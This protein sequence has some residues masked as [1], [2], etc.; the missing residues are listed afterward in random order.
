MLNYIVSRLELILEKTGEDDNLMILS[1]DSK[2]NIQ[3][4]NYIPTSTTIGA[5]L[6][7]VK[8]LLLSAKKARSERDP[9]DCKAHTLD[10]IMRNL[11][12]HWL[13]MSYHL[14]IPYCE[15]YQILY[16]RELAV[17]VLLVEG[18]FSQKNSSCFWMCSYITNYHKTR[19]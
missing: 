7:Y 1:R 10:F 6:F 12:A 18:L 11:E 14:L 2:L 16:K 9:G 5:S 13:I 4:L 19:I 15:V 8:A 17:N 3:K